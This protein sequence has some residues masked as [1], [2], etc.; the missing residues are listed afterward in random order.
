MLGHMLGA[1]SPILLFP[2]EL[3]SAFPFAPNFLGQYILKNLVLIGAG[4]V[5][6]GSLHCS[7]PDP[8]PAA[9]Q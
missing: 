7:S 4:L 2:Q 6:A 9:E 8:S 1:N 5:L 3:F